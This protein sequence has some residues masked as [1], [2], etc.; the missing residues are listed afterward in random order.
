MT[1][2]PPIFAEWARTVD[3]WRGRI[4]DRV[5]LA[6]YLAGYHCVRA[7]WYELIALTRA[8]V[9]VARLARRAVR[10]VGDPDGR[11]AIDGCHE[12][13]RSDLYAKLADKHR[14]AV[15]RRLAFAAF[16]AAA[17]AVFAVMVASQSIPVRLVV[18]LAVVH[19]L[20]RAGG[21]PDRPIVKPADVRADLAPPTEEMVKAALVEVLPKAKDPEQVQTVQPPVKDGRGWQTIVD[22]PAGATA[23]DA[24]ARRVALAGA[25]RRPLGTVWPEPQDDHPARL[26]LWVGSQALADRKL[27]AWPLLDAGAVDLFD[28][29]PFGVDIRDQ[30]VTLR[31]MGA[32][33]VTGA[34]PRMGKTNSARL[35]LLAAALD[36]RAELH[37]FDLKGTGDYSAAEGLCTSYVLGDS[38]A[39]ISA[40][41]EI[42]RRLQADM[43][44]RAATIAGLPRRR[45]PDAKV[46]SELATDPTLRLHPVFVLIDECHLW[47]GHRKHGD[48]LERVVADLAKRGPALGIYVDNVTQEPGGRTGTRPNLPAS[49]MRAAPYRF[50]LRVLEWEANNAVLGTGAH[51]AGRNAMQFT[52]GD[53]GVGILGGDEHARTVQCYYVDN[54]VAERVVARA[55]S[56]R[57]PQGE[58]HAGAETAGEPPQGVVADLLAVWPDG[59]E[60]L[61]LRD[62]G[63]LLSRRWP[64]RYASWDV[65]RLGSALAAEQVPRPTLREGRETRRGVRRVD[66]DDV[67]TPVATPLRPSR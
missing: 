39:E 32:S 67:A 49:I 33:M 8:P 4:V 34:Q 22:L 3:G 35:R 20:A 53:V 41:V 28:P 7:P 30:P 16:A 61:W 11:A 21:D 63:D 25:L 57:A 17:V 9:G 59:A 12:S 65:R 31:L 24:I 52:R 43:R 10:W 6:G 66:L 13:K 44:R 5:K 48:E 60:W 1:D 47:Y 40:G 51:K 23:A 37:V 50:C 27:P 29:F 55:A 26:S 58:T 19:A 54:L 14:D 18:V 56:L 45:A 46:T 42:M 2:R 36:Y 15:Y 62:A 38:D 64:A